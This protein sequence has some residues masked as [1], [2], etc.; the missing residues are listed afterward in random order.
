MN[1]LF[2]ISLHLLHCMSSVASRFKS[3]IDLVEKSE[4]NILEEQTEETN[5]RSG[6]VVS[7]IHSMIE[8][9][10][11]KDIS[12]PIDADL[13]QIL[14]SKDIASKYQELLWHEIEG[15]WILFLSDELVK[16][17]AAIINPEMQTEATISSSLRKIAD[18]IIRKNSLILY[19][20]KEEE[21]KMKEQ[22]QQHEQE[23][24][25]QHELL[26]ASVFQ[27]A[28]D[29][30]LFDI[31][32]IGDIPLLICPSYSDIFSQVEELKELLQNDLDAN[33]PENKIPLL[34][35]II[36]KIHAAINENPTAISKQK[37]NVTAF[38]VDRGVNYEGL[39]SASTSEV[40]DNDF[41]EN[42]NILLCTFTNA[43]SSYYLN[44][45]LRS[46]F[47][48]SS[49]MV[50][51][52]TD[53]PNEILLQQALN[54]LVCTLYLLYPG[55]NQTMVAGVEQQIRN[56]DEIYEL[57]IC[58]HMNMRIPLALSDPVFYM[59]SMLTKDIETTTICPVPEKPAQC[60]HSLTEQFK[61]LI[62][63]LSSV[64]DG[65]VLSNIIEACSL[66]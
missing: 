24:Q 17:F 40:I 22:Q 60:S 23:S 12:L 13:T 53:S 30:D 16:A 27:M 8:G 63:N 37:T 26:E 5:M 48:V 47:P 54:L 28:S 31:N 21:E 1:F 55:L 65:D 15:P 66:Q 11:N 44:T 46:S 39:S 7:K 59:M 45:E 29:P 43:L 35:Q 62:N 61:E 2:H 51:I 42:T 57:R 41:S 50:H 6:G 3:K 52:Q 19:L 10:I 64:V 9:F 49:I 20:Q 36:D 56:D 32:N 34:L 25:R 18:A 38:L 14:N 58:V 4:K 33:Q